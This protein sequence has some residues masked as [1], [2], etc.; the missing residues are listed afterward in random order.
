ME[1]L[2][3]IDDLYQIKENDVKETFILILTEDD[4]FIIN[5]SSDYSKKVAAVFSDIGEV[6][7]LVTG[8]LAGMLSSLAS[9]QAGK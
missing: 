7:D 9:E 3:V 6:L 8:G 4:L 1:I 2:H 5:T